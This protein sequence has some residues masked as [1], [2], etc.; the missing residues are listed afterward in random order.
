MLSCCHLCIQ[1]VSLISCADVHPNP[2]FILPNGEELEYGSRAEVGEAESVSDNWL[3]RPALTATVRLL[4]CAFFG[5]VIRRH[6]TGMG[7]SYMDGDY[8]VGSDEL[9]IQSGPGHAWQVEHVQ[10]PAQSGMDAGESGAASG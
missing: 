5:K 9:I 10:L 6:D 7:E 3:G 8:E 2:R 1:P 4:S